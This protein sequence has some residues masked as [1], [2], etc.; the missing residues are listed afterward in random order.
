MSSPTFSMGKFV[1][2]KNKNKN[3][4]KNKK[5]KTYS[6]Y[7]EIPHVNTKVL[8]ISL[9]K[10]VGWQIPSGIKSSSFVKHKFMSLS[11]MYSYRTIVS[12]I[13]SFIINI[14][15][16]V[17]KT[18][19]HFEIPACIKS[20]I[21]SYYSKQEN[22]WRAVGGI[23]QKL[24]KCKDCFKPL[25][26]NWKIRATMKNIKNV[27]DPVTMEIPK[28]PVYLLDIN[29]RM[30]FVYDA[31]TLR[32]T[33][34]NRILF[35]DYMFAEPLEPVNLLTNE[36]LTYGQLMSIIK[37]C[38]KY[39]EYS[40]V[41][42]E[43]K[44]HGGNLKTFS[45]FNSQKLNLEAINVFFKKSKE[46][47]RETVIDFFV[48]EAEMVDLPTYKLYSF[49]IKYDSEPSHP[50]IQKWIKNTREYYIAKELKNNDLLVKN[51]VNSEK[52]LNEIYLI[53]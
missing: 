15:F 17:P 48:S 33:I 18:N 47:I 29:K 19:E 35:S 40:W 10:Q 53:L 30:S 31:K 5:F 49:N 50:L 12:Y 27:E 9:N 8:K 20:L 7:N 13:K 24:F 37:Q 41:L 4:N 38:K 51:Q 25:I 21:L 46:I 45:V 36:P 32:K 16:K 52:L 28:N 44:I 6:K 39:G 3:I 43:L 1:P 26:F 34:E 2:K 23:Y 42:D 11:N 14:K 22:Q